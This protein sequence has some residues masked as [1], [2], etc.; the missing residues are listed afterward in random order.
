MNVANPAVS[1]PRTASQKLGI[2][3]AG[4]FSKL[5]AHAIPAVYHNVETWA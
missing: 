1:E 4:R 2:H 3:Q 5:L